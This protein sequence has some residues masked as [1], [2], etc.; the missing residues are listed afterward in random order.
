MF[1]FRK[2]CT[3][4]TCAVGHHACD[5]WRRFL[6]G[7][8]SSVCSVYAV[9]TALWKF[10]LRIE[11]FLSISF[12]SF[13]KNTLSIKL[14]LRDE[15]DGNLFKIVKRIGHFFR[16]RRMCTFTNL[17]CCSA[18]YLCDC[19]KNLDNAAFVTVSDSSISLCTVIVV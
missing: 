7:R 9:S 3:L 17:L 16:F 11:K 18:D 5:C 14:F 19:K 8:F 12:L 6:A 15:C 1:Q 2:R 13:V 4:P 10:L